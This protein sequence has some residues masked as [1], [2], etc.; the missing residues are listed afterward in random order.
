MG[1]KRSER[2]AGRRKTFILH[3]KGGQKQGSPP[4]RNPKKKRGVPIFLRIEHSK[5]GNRWRLN[6]RGQEEKE[7]PLPYSYGRK[8]SAS[9]CWRKG[10]PCCLSSRESKPGK[11]PGK[12]KKILFSHYHGR[13]N[14]A[15]TKKPV[16]R[17][18]ALV[19][20]KQE[21]RKSNR[22]NSSSRGEKGGE[23]KGGR[24]GTNVLCMEK[25]KKVSC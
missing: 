16:G 23:K 20:L 19:T 5:K 7:D 13:K 14:G 10:R 11:L 24:P 9:C 8:K 21:E 15:I 22:L 12:G 4:P 18:V 25:G 6:N 1:E 3:Y 2:S 17:G